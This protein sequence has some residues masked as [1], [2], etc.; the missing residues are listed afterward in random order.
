MIFQAKILSI[1]ELPHTNKTTGEQ[2]KKIEIALQFSNPTEFFV[3]TFW[4]KQI[5]NKDHLPYKALLGHQCQIYGSFDTF[6]NRLQLRLS[7]TPPRSLQ[8]KV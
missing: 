7:Q 2:Q 1:D 5:D 8:E 4:Q 3:A 6:N